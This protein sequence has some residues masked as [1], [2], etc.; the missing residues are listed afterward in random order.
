MTTAT[1]SATISGGLATRE[2]SRR[3]IQ[4]GNCATGCAKVSKRFTT[5]LRDDLMAVPTRLKQRSVR[6]LTALQSAACEI[7]DETRLLA[8]SFGSATR[9]RVPLRR[10]PARSR[11]ARDSTLQRFNVFSTLRLRLL[12]ALRRDR[13]RRRH[14]ALPR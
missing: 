14:E 12:S 6:G 7:L 10:A 5:R 2:N 3:I 9:P 4:L 1:A 13:L 11:I 8:R